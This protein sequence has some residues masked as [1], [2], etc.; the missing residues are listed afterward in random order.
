L[1]FDSLPF[2]SLLPLL[3]SCSLTLEDLIPFIGTI[4]TLSGIC[5]YYIT[6]FKLLSLSLFFKLFSLL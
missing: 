3:F 6:D 4:L 5:T 2:V 1:F